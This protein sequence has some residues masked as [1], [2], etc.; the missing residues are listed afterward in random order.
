MNGINTDIKRVQTVEEKKR[1]AVREIQK[2]LLALARQ[3]MEVPRLRI[4]GVYGPETAEGVR[5]FQALMG[6]PVTGVVDLITW[7]ILYSEYEGAF[8]GSSLSE[9]IYPFEGIFTDGL[10]RPSERGNI[11]YILQIMLET[12]AEYYDSQVKQ[13]INGIFDEITV[14]NL[15]S[16]QRANNLTV[17]GV[18]DRATWDVLSR[19]Y[20]E[21][22]NRE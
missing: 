20:N 8:T 12:V 9:P 21:Y 13:V 16:F 10:V 22:L 5:I 18:L 1:R 19:L 15:K 11:V 2:Y 17:T 14:E 4:D 6:I 3:G 7:N